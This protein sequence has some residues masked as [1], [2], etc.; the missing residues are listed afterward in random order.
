M[1]RKFQW[2]EHVANYYPTIGF[3]LQELK[4]AKQVTASPQK[5]LGLPNERRPS[6][7]SVPQFDE[8][9]ESSEQLMISHEGKQ[10]NM[11]HQAK[12]LS[13]NTASK[14]VFVR[15]ALLRPKDVFVSAL[16]V[17]SMQN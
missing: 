5:L 10:Q 2:T 8:G 7:S 9:A 3:F 6:Y 1:W 15:L 4:V 13:N 16:Y 12:Q 17:V 11:P 14:A